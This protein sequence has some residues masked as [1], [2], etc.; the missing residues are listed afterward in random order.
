[1][2]RIT[3]IAVVTFFLDDKFPHTSNMQKP[4]LSRQSKWII[5]VLEHLSAIF[6]QMSTFELFTNF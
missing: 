3:F 6:W 2:Q 4:F 5:A 1:M